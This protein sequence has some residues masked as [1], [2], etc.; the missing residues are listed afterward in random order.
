[1]GIVLTL[2]FLDSIPV[3]V[4]FIA[5]LV[6][7]AFI[8]G[9][10][11]LWEYEVDFRHKE[12]IGSGEVEFESKKKKGTTIEC[13]F[14]LEEPYRNKAIEIYLNE[15]LIFTIKDS[16]NYSRRI[17]I[18]RNIDLDQPKPGDLVCVKID[19]QEIFSGPLVRD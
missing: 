3:W 10:K 18:T 5:A 12:G 4:Y 11:V 13:E 19:G 8:F 17:D 2:A 14:S 16:E 6:I 15:A 9:D 7:Y 1:M